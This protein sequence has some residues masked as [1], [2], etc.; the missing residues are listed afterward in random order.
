MEPLAV[1][2][3]QHLATALHLGSVSSS[4]DA[5]RDGILHTSGVAAKARDRMHPGW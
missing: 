5:P 2:S 3:M 1:Q 4:N